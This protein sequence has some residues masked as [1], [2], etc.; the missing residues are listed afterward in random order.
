MKYRNDKAG[1][2]ISI[3]G[4]G[5]MRFPKKG[6]KIDYV[7]AEEQ[8]LEAIHQ[9]VN[10]F[11]TAYVYSGSEACLGEILEKN[12]KRNDIYIATKLPHYL[13]KSK[14]AMEKYFQEQLKRLK[15]DYIDYYLMH[16]LT[17]VETWQRLKKLGI[18]DWIKQKLATGQI[19]NIGFSYH[20]N[21]DMFIQLI[22]AFPWDFTQI[23]YN[24][25]DE[26]SQAGRRGLQ[27]AYQKNI[28]V[29]IME[30]L[31]G[32]KLVDLLPN[33]AKE[34]FKEATPLRSAAEWALRWLWDQKEVTCV[35]SGMNS[36]EMVK[37]NIKIASSVEVGEF[38]ESDFKVVEKVK[39]AI[40]QKIKVNCTGCGYC[41]PCVKG[42]D[43][44][45]SFRCYNVA[46]TEKKQTGKHEYLMCT[47]F[48][49]EASS[50]SLCIKCGKCVKHCPQGID[51][52]HQ[53]ENVKKELETPTYK[54]AR[55]IIKTLRIW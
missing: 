49:K 11:D 29:I 16:M 4:F 31:R 19:K 10:Y 21:S 33:Q 34:I 55:F 41:L 26:H 52:P 38:T 5:C 13:I 15:T 3:L 42:V 12:H 30:P 46:Y 8:I 35:L 1:N 27:Y 32:G 9:G 51:I 43:I 20:G 14:S 50:A 54:I 28:P 45:G 17:D 48:R 40:N 6:N 23:Q 24:Y 36:L 37:E 22:D 2:E 18:E 39:Q 7:K 44:P 47:A 53:L 25:M